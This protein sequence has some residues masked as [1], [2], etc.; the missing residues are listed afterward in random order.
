MTIYQAQ[1]GSKI[2]LD[3]A[4][5][6]LVDAFALTTQRPAKDLVAQAVELLRPTLL[7]KTRKG[8]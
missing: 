2:D 1:D 3:P 5:V 8:A 6:K 7:A 4:T